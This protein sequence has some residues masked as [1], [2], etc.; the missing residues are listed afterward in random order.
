MGL[1]CQIGTHFFPARKD[2]V[3][4]ISIIPYWYLILRVLSARLHG[5]DVVTVSMKESESVSKTISFCA[6][7]G[8]C[9]FIKL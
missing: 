9:H 1:F 4:A 6:L 8:Y 2:S 3:L 5:G 7:H